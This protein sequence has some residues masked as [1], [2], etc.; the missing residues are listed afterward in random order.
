MNQSSIIY[1][2][3]FLRKVESPYQVFVKE[4]IIQVRKCMFQ[5][6]MERCETGPQ[7]RQRLS[8]ALIV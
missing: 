1:D 6:R 3:S 8:Q 7:T 4:K 2:Q 5:A